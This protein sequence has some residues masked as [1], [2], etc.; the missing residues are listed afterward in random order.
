MDEQVTVANLIRR[1]S[2]QGVSIVPVAKLRSNP[3]VYVENIDELEFNIFDLE[4]VYGKVR[5]LDILATNIF[6]KYS[7]FD[8]LEVDYD[9]F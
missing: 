2:K 1:R 7:L 3:I 8:D 6:T 4:S 5:T 9:V